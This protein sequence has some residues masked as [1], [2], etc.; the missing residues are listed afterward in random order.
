M[1]KVKIS[2]FQFFSLLVLFE[3]GT[4]I[5]VPLGISSKQDSWLAIL[6]GLVGGIA[7][8]ML[9]GLLFRMHPDSALL[10]YAKIIFGKWIGTL[11]GLL[12]IIFF[13]Y[14]A[15]RDLRDGGEFLQTAM[16]DQTPL[17]ALNALMIVT[18]TYVLYS[19]IEVFARTGE[20]F[21]MIMI[22]LG[23]IGV[24]LILF[25]N[26]MD[27]T[28]LQPVFGSGWDSIL[29]AAYPQM[30][31]FPFGETI[32][33]TMIFPYV[34]KL[35]AGIKTGTAAIV[36]SGVILCLISL[37]EVSVLGVSIVARTTFP[38]LT[39]VSKVNI[40]NFLQRL[41]MIVVLALI[42]G[43]FFKVALFFIAAAL[44]TARLFRLPKYQD[45]L[46]PIAIVILLCSM[47]IAS[48]FPQHLAQ[49]KFVLYNVILFFSLIIPLLL[50]AVALIRAFATRKAQSRS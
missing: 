4:A 15:A 30:F 24:L 27:T 20:I 49:G 8:F 45:A 50:L 38:L 1:E 10:D 12:Y 44:G 23:V 14:G 42:I 2:S 22:G 43:D 5:V 25:S 33:F 39:T 37:V 46:L 9:Y 41:D 13:I 32:C 34:N 3:L 28:N 48:N 47:F 31:M 29:H 16:Y 35:A 11:L 7:L 6:L 40:A 19:G 36:F 26:I 18:I 17:F 21:F